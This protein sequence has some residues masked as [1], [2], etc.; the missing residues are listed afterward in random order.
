[1][2]KPTLV[3]LAAGMGSRYGG[4]K[5]VDPV[6]PSGETLMDYSIFDAQ[7]AGFNRVVFVI[8]R[9]FEEIFRTQIGNRY[10]DFIEVDY[11]FQE[12][13]D[14]PAGF[15]PATPRTKPWGTAHAIRAARHV[16]STPFAAINADDFYG[17]SS[18]QC[19]GDFLARDQ[20]CNTKPCF[21]MVGY[22]LD[23]TLTTHG[24]VARGICYTNQTGQLQK[25]VEMTKLVRVANGVENREPGK[26]PILLQGSERVSLNLWG[27]TSALFSLIEERFPQWLQTQGNTPGAEWFIPFVI[28]SMISDGVAEVQLLP[29][30]STW[31]GVTY[32]EDKPL[33]EKAIRQLVDQGEYPANL[34]G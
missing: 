19:L 21:A 1:M 26:D 10:S 16:V 5:Q 11:A 12:L 8:R 18:F 33:V 15:K 4:L 7:R 32:R 14:L 13:D 25:V 29:T 3:I 23:Q 2:Q 6:G 24:S 34:W 31:F 17:R 22:R 20:A 30:E 27:F 28:D 9:D